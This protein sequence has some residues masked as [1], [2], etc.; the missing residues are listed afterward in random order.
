MISFV[1]SSKYPFIAGCG[2]SEN[3]TAGHIRELQRR[4]IV[5]RIICIGHDI[6][7]SQADFPDITFVKVQ[8]AK[9][10][11]EIDDTILFITYPLDIKTKHKSYVILHCPPPTLSGPDPLFVRDAFRGK[12]LIAVSGMGAGLWRK[13]LRFSGGKISIVYPFAEPAF[14][15][16]QRPAPQSAQSN[17][18][19]LFAGRLTPDKGIYTLLAALHMSILRQQQVTVTVTDAG[20][21]THDGRI[22]GALC[23]AHPGIQ[24]VAA[25]KSAPSMARL[26]AQH[27]AVIMPTTNIFWRETFGMV[28]VEA[29]HAGC[30]VV[31]SRAGGL[32]ETN[33][34]G[35]ILTGPDNPL[36]LAKGIA[37][38]A[39]L[40]PLTTAQ[41]TNAISKFTV[42]LS[43]DSLLR[44]IG[45]SPRLLPTLHGAYLPGVFTRQLVAGKARN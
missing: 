22:I 11:Q 5:C 25:R 12:K 29:Q 17:M 8:S 40:G 31:A 2:G 23:Q 36:S 43:V 28:S 6:A 35:L 26:M 37:K 9:D 27:D 41:R 16:I 3:Y 44:V 4:S 21:N 7:Q 15:K 13:Y 18:R 24:L 32:P 19:L 39:M 45:Y 30:R 38:A 1:W 34:G 10:L 42:Q 33:C 14:S 20:K